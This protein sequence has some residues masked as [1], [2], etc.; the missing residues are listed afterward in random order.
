MG[1]GS[2]PLARF[3]G[4]SRE[5]SPRRRARLDPVHELGEGVGG[6]RPLDPF[7]PA[8][9]RRTMRPAVL[10]RLPE[11]ALAQTGPIPVSAGWR[12]EPEGVVAKRERDPYRP[13][14][15]VWVKTKNRTKARFAEESRVGEQRAR[16]RRAAVV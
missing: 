1:D 12:F 9:E 16:P 15:R 8:R 14:E 6:I 5:R 7:A 11:P 4:V 13:G 2:M 10:L 3:G